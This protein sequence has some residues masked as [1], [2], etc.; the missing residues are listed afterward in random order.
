[1]LLVQ[2]K[3]EFSESE[4][5][6]KNKEDKKEGHNSSEKHFRD[7]EGGFWWEAK[8]PR[9]LAIQSLVTF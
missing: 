3:Q 4:L 6:K 7:D 2:S 8:S 1:M 9:G 5:R